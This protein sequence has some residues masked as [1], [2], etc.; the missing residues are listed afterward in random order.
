M[1]KM[2]QNVL[3]RSSWALALGIL[4]LVF[5]GEM[6]RG[7]IYV[8]GFMFVDVG[9]VALFR[10]FRNK[11]Q[12]KPSSLLAVAAV[13]STLF[14]VVQLLFPDMFFEALRY[15][16][17]GTLALLALLQLFALVRIRCGGIQLSAVYY[18]LPF[19]GLGLA[20]AVVLHPAFEAD[21]AL[22]MKFIGGGFVLC[23]LLELWVFFG[24]RRLAKQAFS[25][26]EAEHL[27]QK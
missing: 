25:K 9:V 19:L 12:E 24:V 11:D 7:I 20:A 27:E 2:M 26:Q 17:S 6:S 5:S 16:L 14:G 8:S 21:G 1:K 3:L 22:A 23:T 13:G 4:L 18:L 15:L 10:N